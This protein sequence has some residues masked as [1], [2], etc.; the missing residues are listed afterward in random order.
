MGLVSTL[1]GHAFLPAASVDGTG[2]GAGFSA[3]LGIGI[4][5]NDN[6]LVVDAQGLKI[7]KI[8]QAGVVTTIAGSGSPG[9]SD[10]NGSA[11]S[12][13][14]RMPLPLMPTTICMSPM[15]AQERSER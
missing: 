2:G 10:G 9:T 3:P 1:A 6:L 13:R 4:D 7:R 12:F 15:P 5:G 14:D 8:T 11:A